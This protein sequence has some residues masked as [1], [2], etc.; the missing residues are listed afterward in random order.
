MLL[1]SL[2]Y[3]RPDTLEEAFEALDQSDGVARPLAGGQSLI[4]LLKLRAA[5]IDLLVDISRLETL[6]F[7]E[8]KDDGSVEIGACVTYD[9]MARSPELA[10]AHPKMAEVA[11]FTVD[12]QVRNRGTL[13]GNLCH[14]DPI[15]NFP[16]LAVALGATL[17]LQG[18]SSQRKVA[19]ED[20]FTGYFSSDV[21]PGEVVR[22]ITFP[23]LGE[24]Y[25]VGYRD[26]EIGEAAA[27][28]V[29]LVQTEGNK[30]TD[31]RLV[32]GCL[33]VPQRRPGAEEAL[34]G[35]ATDEGSVAEA[36]ASVADGLEFLTDADA[37]A[38][39]RAAIAPV[40]AKRAV[41]QAIEEGGSQ[42]G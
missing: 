16:P 23:A 10:S 36:T 27:R 24:G 4:S 9:E 17:H 35:S 5:K 41:L 21:Q 12:A 32:M 37:S 31:A 30:I 8:A 38:E 29:A 6:R 14:N 39:Y 13:G 22:S 33:P 3:Y 2:D 19:A 28:A 15:N 40:V 25:R 1:A 11:A 34:K 18:S 7:I 42:D 20:F 26:I